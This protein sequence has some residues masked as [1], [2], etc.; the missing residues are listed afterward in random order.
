LLEAVCHDEASGFDA[1]MCSDH[2]APWS[3]PQ[4]ESPH[5]WAWLSAAMAR[6][7][8]PFGVVNAPGQRYHP[9]IVAQAAAILSEMF[10][11][12][13]WMALGSGEALNEHVTGAPWPNKPTRDQRLLECVDVIRA[14]LN[15]EEVSHHGLV[16]V[17]RA[18]LWTLPARPPAL[19]GRQ[20]RR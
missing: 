4:G 9:V 20:S 3:Q 17:D 13:L 14:L 12:R 18:R 15:G 10:P 6:T 1:A 5:A 8:V 11:D 2:L 19:I 16:K 7:R